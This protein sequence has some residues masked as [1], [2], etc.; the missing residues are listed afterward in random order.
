MNENM[1]DNKIHMKHKEDKFG[2][3]TAQESHEPELQSFIN[4][5]SKIYSEEAEFLS[6]SLPEVTSQPFANS[7]HTIYRMCKE[8][9]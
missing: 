5:L 6:H 2:K 1:K 3:L 8:D 9:I 7:L 4:S